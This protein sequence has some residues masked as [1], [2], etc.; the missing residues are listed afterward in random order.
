MCDTT[1]LYHVSLCSASQLPGCTLAINLL[2][3]QYPLLRLCKNALY[4]YFLFYSDKNGKL[5]AYEIPA[6]FRSGTWIRH[7]IAEGFKPQ[8]I[9]ITE[10]NGAPGISQ[11]FYPMD[12]VH[13]G[14]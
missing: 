4:E 3:R 6:D 14:R 10:G 2:Y 11:A 9:I 1:I 13:D 7:G 8:G 12:P 5:V